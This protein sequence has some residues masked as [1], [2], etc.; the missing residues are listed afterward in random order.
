[1]RTDVPFLSGQRVKVEGLGTGRV[2][3]CKPY[4]E[5]PRSRKPRW[6][7]EIRRDSDGMMYSVKA[8]NVQPT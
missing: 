4:Y 7:V 2:R 5:H 6:A 3:A 1:V 8:E